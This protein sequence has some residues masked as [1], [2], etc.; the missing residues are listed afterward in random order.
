MDKEKI[1]EAAR[2]DKYIGK[3]YENKESARSNLLGSAVAL[4][5][6]VAIVATRH[7][8]VPSCNAT[9]HR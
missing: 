5:V 3:E 8:L 7:L 1:L 2:N 6:G 4:L 9:G